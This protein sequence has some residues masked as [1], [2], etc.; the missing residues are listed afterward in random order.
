MGNRKAS[1]HARII[2]GWFDSL[3]VPKGAPHKANA[4]KFVNFMM[5]AE[6]GAALSDLNRYA[7]PLDARAISTHIDPAFGE[8]QEINVDASVAVHFSETCDSKAIKMY[9]RV[10]TKV[11]Q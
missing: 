10:W 5:A 1:V 3:V 9:D 4:E 6:N 8:A 11:L 2:I 7:S